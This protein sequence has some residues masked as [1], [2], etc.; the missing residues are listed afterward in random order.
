MKK[1]C[2]A[3]LSAALCGVA[4]SSVVQADVKYTETM[5][6]GGKN[7][8]D[9]PP[10]RNTTYIKAGLERTEQSLSMGPVTMKMISVSSC[11]AKRT[12]RFDPALKI[13]TSTPMNDDSATKND[14]AKAED[15][16]AAPAAKDKK[17]T[18]KITIT[19]DVQKLGTEEIAGR[20]ARHY[21]IKQSMV[22]E[23]CAGNGEQKYTMELW[24]ADYDMPVFACRTPWSSS[25]APTTRPTPGGCAITTEFKG[26]QTA[27]A[28][29]YRGLQVKRKMTMGDTVMTWQL[30][31][32]SE[33]KLDD[34]LFAP[35]ADWK[36]V[37]DE[38]F[39]RQRQAA[40]MRAMTSGAAAG[41]DDGD[42]GDKDGDAKADED[43]SDAEKEADSAA[44]KAAKDAAKETAKDA[45]RQ[46]NKGRF[47]LPF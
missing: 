34:S 9:M 45:A 29:A 39:D 37:T 24:T 30:T 42:D 44:E 21:I 41:G 3:I 20:T 13:Y 5:T 12:M 4:L 33:A 19:A 27:I 28:E 16:K 25:A 38:E 15:T 14:E 22:S 26:D 40:M 18:G 11:P 31:E 8:A 6:M 2:T 10:S 36:L 7:A 17:K 1:F 23:G 47:K 32:L 46:K 43:K 35:G